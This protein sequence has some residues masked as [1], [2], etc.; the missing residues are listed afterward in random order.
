MFLI[1]DS[2][3]LGIGDRTPCKPTQ[4]AGKECEDL[5][6]CYDGW[7]QECYKPEKGYILL[8]LHDN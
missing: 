4:P 5:G 7:L 2:C 3:N 6:C 1:I 8:P